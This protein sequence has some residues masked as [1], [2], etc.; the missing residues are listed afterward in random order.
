M[1]RLVCRYASHSVV[2]FSTVLLV[3]L[4]SF[5]KTIH[6][7]ADQPTI[8][9]GI[10]AASNGDTVLVS[11]GTYK[12]NISFNGKSITVASQSGPAVT[13]IDG[14]QLTAVVTFSGGETRQAVLRGFTV[15]NG[16]YAYPGSGISISG[17]SPTIEGNVVILN[18]VCGNAVS[19][20]NG[21]PLIQNNLIANNN[22]SCYSQA[23]Y[24]NYDTS[25]DVIGNVI[26]DNPFGGI[27]VFYPSGNVNITAN[28][29][30]DNG[31]SGIIYNSLYGNSANVVGNL[32]TRNQEGGISLGSSPVTLVN[33]TV[34][35]NNGQQCCSSGAEVYANTVD[36]Q[37]TID[38][39][40]I[41]GNTSYPALACG[42]YNADPVFQH[43]DVFS[44]EGPGYG[45]VCPD[46]TGSNGNISVDPLFAAPLSGDLHIQSHSPAVNAGTNSAPNLPKKDFDGDP[47]ILGKVID[48]GVDEYS[49]KTTLT[50]STLNLYYAQTQV[51]QTSAPQAV[52]LTNHGTAAIK[53]NL[54]ATGS[55]FTQNNNCGTSLPA[56][57]NCQI[58]VT[59][60]PVGGGVRNSVLGIFT[61]ATANPQTVSLRGTGLA[62]Q[63][64]LDTTYISF[65]N[66]IIGTNGQQQDNLTN[67]GQAPLAITSFQMTGATDFSQTNNCPI[68]PN[69]LAPGAYCT[70]TVSYTPTMMGYENATLSI[71]DNA[72]PSPQ[73]I[74]ISGNSVSAGYPT[75]NPTNLTF[76]DTLIG[77]TSDPQYVTLTNTG[78]G[79]LGNISVY[80]YGDFPTSNDCPLSLPAGAYC[81]ITVSFSPLYLGQDYST[82]WVYNDSPYSGQIY[83]SGNG[84]APLPT[85]TSLS[86][87]NLAATSA[88][89]QILINGTGFVYGAQVSWNGILLG[90][91]VS[92]STQLYLSAPTDYLLNPGTVQIAVVNPTPG[93]GTSNSATFTIYP[94]TNYSFRSV[95]YRY[96]KITGTNMNLSYYEAGWITSPFPIQFGGGSFTNLELDA[97]GNL[98]FIAS[99][100]ESN[101]PIPDPYL[102]TVIAPFWT[103]LYPWGTG[104]DNNVF[105]AVT[106]TAPNRH[107]VVEWRDV[108]LCCDS[109]GQYTVKFQVVFA[110]NNPEVQFNYADTEFGGP[111]SYA[112]NGA[113]ATVGIQVTPSLATQYSYYTPSLSSQTS[114]LWYPSSPNV[115][116]STSTLDFGY[117]LI[118]TR[119]NIQ[120]VTLTNGG[121]APLQISSISIDDPDFAQGNNCGN[122][123]QPG[124]SCTIHVA[125]TPSQ[126]GL[127]SG[128]L[129]ITDDGLGGMQTVSLSG[130]GATTPVVIFPEYLNFGSVQVGTK[131]TLPVTLANAADKELTIQQ[132]VAQPGVYTQSN[133]C[134]SA[135]DPGA[136]CAINVTFAPTK[137]GTVNGTLQLGIKGKPPKNM[138]RLTG[139]GM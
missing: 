2:A 100:T 37:V 42:A 49:P 78:T 84:L 113:T 39:N 63:V 34:F 32:V 21:G 25:D 57:S 132:I 17:A 127:E 82:I 116:L 61:G 53:L 46:F 103:G 118:G 5:G 45:G 3:V 4:P 96:E 111:Y 10:D 16:G 64:Q 85:I 18:N 76:P 115:S 33:N 28:A 125:F 101:Q 72:S 119:S 107:L 110:E 22:P 94:A 131:S 133:N 14:Q 81:T 19:S 122:I 109:S 95:P 24:L 31:S 29:I 15:Q 58:N 52:T 6:V 102:D 91:T 68:A 56:G 48:I 112:D 62:P 75:L 98:S 8:Q 123:V 90:G 108:S 88:N 67:T 50:L 124:H 59:F 51:G 69:T 93:G 97:G 129:T 77:S 20:D 44:T 38:N 99:G 87:N 120:K 26:S 105:W 65:Y 86:P 130:I 7:P 89:T 79:P 12:E 73:Q 47:R 136:Y 74:G 114:L 60:A 104:T 35:N 139:T 30:V 36:N 13:I 137:K 41:I 128:T 54:I 80:S 117:H 126:P 27:N 11:P 121:L 135:L 55:D 83:V 134:G 138:V 70:I 106:G 66:Q 43:N 23:V 1:R 9:A 40:L 71:Y 92:N